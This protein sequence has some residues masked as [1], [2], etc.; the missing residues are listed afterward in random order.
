VDELTKAFE[1]IHDAGDGNASLE[2]GA[3][4]K[5][6][7]ELFEFVLIFFNL[8]VN[9]RHKTAFEGSFP[10]QMKIRVRVARDK[11][12]GSHT[13]VLVHRIVPDEI[14]AFGRLLCHQRNNSAMGLDFL[15]RFG[16]FHEG[17]NV[18]H[19]INQVNDA[20]VPVYLS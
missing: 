11:G 9:V 4:L 3:I 17:V 14:C 15:D 18:V 7:F 10:W 5:R 1:V 12:G 2:D 6:H 8:A 20:A 16:L 19:D 13:E